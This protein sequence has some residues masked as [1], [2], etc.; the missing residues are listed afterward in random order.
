MS[1]N[2]NEVQ[3]HAGAAAYDQIPSQHCMEVAFWGRSNVGKSSLIGALI[4]NKRFMRISK[5]PGCTRQIN[6]FRVNDTVHLVDL[7]GYG[8]AKI[9]KAESNSWGVLIDRYIQSR[10]VHV[11][12][13]IDA[14]RGFMASDEAVIEY[15]AENNRNFSIIFTKTD[16]KSLSEEAINEWQLSLSQ[17]ESFSGLIYKTSSVKKNGIDI[18]RKDIEKMTRNQKF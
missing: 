5:T 15:L 16:K 6:F 7:P 2:F 9:S 10:K 12:L 8:Y 3:F 11:M 4:N 13:L 17:Y 1:I 18:I 14:R